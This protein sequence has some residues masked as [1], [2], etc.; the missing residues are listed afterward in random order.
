MYTPNALFSTT[1][2][3]VPMTGY[4]MNSFPDFLT[5]LLLLL[6]G[7]LGGYLITARLRQ[8]TQTAVVRRDAVLLLE[9]IEKVFKVVMAEGY[10]T[11]IYN[12]QDQ[13]KILYVL[14]D[15][16][17]AMVIAKAKVLVGFDFAKLRFRQ[18]EPGSRQLIIEAFPEPEVLSIDT[19]Y[20]FYDINPGVLNYFKG[21]DYTK[22]LEEAKHVMNERALQS[23]LPRIANNQVQYMMYQLTESMG[24]T[25]QLP[26]AEAQ[27]LAELKQ[28][29]DRT[30]PKLLPG[31]AE[32]TPTA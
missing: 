17:K 28:L 2:D 3:Y 32:T 19:D 7:G 21:D 12:Y 20:Q 9:R 5:I 6:V 15:P 4:P 11:E 8:Q 13:K 23:D 10:F 29:A 24:W 16:K 30:A 22:I 26:P 25:L 27:R 18:P 1:I 31:G 14:N